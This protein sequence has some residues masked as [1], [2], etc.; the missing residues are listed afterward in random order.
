MGLYAVGNF[1]Y[2]TD[3]VSRLGLSDW[4][5]VPSGVPQGTKLGRWLF[6]LMIDDLS[7]SSVFGMWKYVD[8]TTVSE[9]KP[10]GQCRT[11]Q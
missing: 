3:W 5:K 11:M 8:D 10:K 4:D 6:L 2:K 9:C 1:R 7:L